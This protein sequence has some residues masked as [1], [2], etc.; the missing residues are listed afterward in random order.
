MI[1][2]GVVGESNMEV[3]RVSCV[4]PALSVRGKA[5]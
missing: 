4:E 2:L 5:G 3:A 1:L